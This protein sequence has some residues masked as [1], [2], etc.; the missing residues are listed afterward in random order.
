MVERHNANSR[1]TRDRA[2]RSGGITSDPAVYLMVR[3][4]LHQRHRPG[5]MLVDVGCGN[6]VLW[7]FVD[8][9][10]DRYIGVDLVRY[11]SFPGEAEFHEADLNVTIPLPDSMAE[12]IAA[13]ETVEHLENPRRFMRELVRIAKPGGWVVVTTPNQLSF[14]S[15]ATLLV[16][17]RFESFQDVHYPAHL[18]ALLEVDLRRMASECGLVEMEIDYSLS[19]R[20]AFTA[21]RYPRVLARLSRRALSDNLL[22]V[23]KKPE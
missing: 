6:G 19:G 8:G 22:V 14:L 20:I 11:N 9:M 13:V 4:V 5:G 18:T 21:W 2:L 3:R 23:G 16:K 15:L 7:G 17:N 12:V 1:E 10:F